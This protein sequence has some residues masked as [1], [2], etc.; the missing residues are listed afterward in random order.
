MNF[1]KHEL[2]TNDYL[3]FKEPRKFQ[4]PKL[5]Q[6]D[7]RFEFVK[8]ANSRFELNCLCST[9]YSK[10]VSLFFDNIIVYNTFFDKPIAIFKHELNDSE[11]IVLCLQNIL[12]YITFFDKC[13]ALLKLELSD[14]EYIVLCFGDIL[15]Y[16]NFFDM[17][18]H[19]TFPK[20]YEKGTGEN[21]G[22]NDQSIKYESLSKLETQQTNLEHC[23]AANLD[24][25]AVRGSYLNNQRALTN[26][27]N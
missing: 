26:K 4:E 14:P 25:G 27:I 1:P 11:H 24:I 17:I 15:V 19:L 3:V 20:Q 5:H 23:L 22:Y 10:R 8:S 6:S 21:R 18:T 7:I 16:N 9:N 13:G 12:I 2:V